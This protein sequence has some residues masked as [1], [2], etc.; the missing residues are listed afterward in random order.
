MPRW[1]FHCRKCDTT[2][3]R[4]YPSF[5]DAEWATC[6]NCGEPVVRLPATG[7]FT[8]KGFRAQNGY[9]NSH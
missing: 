9:S 7:A 1:D 2:E 6:P 8:I 5:K 4:S 3:E